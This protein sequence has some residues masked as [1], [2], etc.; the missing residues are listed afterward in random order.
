MGRIMSGS[1]ASLPLFL[2]CVHL[3]PLSWKQLPQFLFATRLSLL[4]PGI[5]AG[6]SRAG[7]CGV[8]VLDNG[9]RTMVPVEPGCVLSRSMRTEGTLQERSAGR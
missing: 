8:V 9:S 5:P 1:R 6:L 3:L 4:F 2:S 7:T